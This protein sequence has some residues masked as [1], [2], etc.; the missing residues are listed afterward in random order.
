M[1]CLPYWDPVDHTILGTLHN[2][3]EGILKNHL[4]VLWGIGRDDNTEQKLKDIDFEEY[5]TDA[6]V[7]ESASELEELCQEAAEHSAEMAHAM[8]QMLP[9][10]PSSPSPVDHPSLPS[11]PT[12]GMFLPDSDTQDLDLLDPDFIPWHIPSDD[13]P[14]SFSDD[15]LHTIQDC[16]TLPT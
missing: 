10:D 13:P 7:L 1:H 15:Q 16:I 11:T 9:P 2:W 8:A 12:Q 5:W 4:H 14:F 6:D 3:E